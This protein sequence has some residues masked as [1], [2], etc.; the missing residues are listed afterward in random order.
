MKLEGIAKISEKVKQLFE[1][2]GSGH[3]W[4]HIYRVQK[5]A[6]KIAKVEQAN[7]ELVNYIALLHDIADHKLTNKPEKAL[8][9]TNEWLIEA[10]LSSKKIELVLDSISNLSFK[11]AKVPDVA[12]S[13]EAT[14]VQD[15]DRLD[16]IGAIGIARAF[17]YGGSKARLIY[18]P[19]EKPQMHASTE[20]YRKSKSSTINH[21][22]E[23]L[24]HL[25]E[26]MVTA[27]AKDMA[28]QRHQFMIDFLDRFYNEWNGK[29]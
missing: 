8:H 4:W 2:E 15:A 12:L 10:G 22:Y 21:F 19:D 23:K 1:Q 13:L 11:G 25:Q 5:L 26:R 28:F 14:I 9:K 24:L 29:S 3:D 27:T 18:L 7:I 16:A 17:A 6:I 20:A